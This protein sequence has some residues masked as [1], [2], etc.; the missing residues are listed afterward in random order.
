M[1]IA[2]LT[3]KSWKSYRGEH[4]LKLEPT[5]YAIAA[6]Y[7]GDADRSNF[8]GKSS[9]VQAVDYALFGRIPDEYQ[10]NEDWI[11][12]GERVGEVSLTLSTGH[13]I[14]RSLHRGAST[15]VWCFPPGV[16]AVTKAAT[17]AEANEKIVQI[18]GL[19]G[20][21]FENTCLFRQKQ[22][23][24]FVLA[25]PGERMKIV[26]RG[27]TSPPWSAARSVATPWWPT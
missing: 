23:A 9:I 21:D 5:V 15:K 26:V 22:M 2:E 17:Q 20:A 8:A 25:E 12:E 7:V 24:R 11:S 18:V 14:V 6:H 19:D 10:A 13:R 27:S 1:H 4:T 16:D 3:M